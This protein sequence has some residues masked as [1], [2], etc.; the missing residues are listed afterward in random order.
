MHDRNDYVLMLSFDL[1]FAIITPIFLNRSNT[2]QKIHLMM[3]SD[4]K[5]IDFVP[6]T[7]TNY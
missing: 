7:V 3:V 1:V 6:V 4:G 2:T 5:W